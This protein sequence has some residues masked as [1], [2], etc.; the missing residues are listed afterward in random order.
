MAKL[1][2]RCVV[3][4]NSNREIFQF[5]RDFGFAVDALAALLFPGAAALG[6]RGIEVFAI[7]GQIRLDVACGPGLGPGDDR[8]FGVPG[9]VAASSCSSGGRRRRC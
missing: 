8:I 5:Y 1:G 6:T 3:A 2:D 9:T 4:G 7:S